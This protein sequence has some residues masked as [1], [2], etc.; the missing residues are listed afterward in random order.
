MT[1]CISTPTVEGV[2]YNVTYLLDYEL[3]LPVVDCTASAIK[4]GDATTAKLVYLLRLR[5]H[6]EDVALLSVA[7]SNQD[8]QGVSRGDRGSAAVTTL[9]LI[10]HANQHTTYDFALSLGYPYAAF[11]FRAYEFL[12][13]TSDS[14]WMV[15]RIPNSI[16]H[17]RNDPPV[18]L[19]TARRTGFYL[20]TE[21]MQSNIINNIW[22]L[23]SDPKDAIG[24]REWSGV[25]VSR[26]SW[27]WV[28]CI[29]LVL[30]TEVVFHLAVLLL[31][32]YNNLRL[33]KVWIGGPFAA[34]STTLLFRGALVLL[35]WV[36]D[37]FW[38]LLEFV[39]SDASLIS[40]AADV[41]IDPSIMHIDLLTIYLSC[42]GLVGNL[43]RERVD[44]AL[45][46]ILFEL[47]FQF[48]IRILTW[49]PSIAAKAIDSSMRNYMAGNLVSDDDSTLDS[50]MRAWGAHPMLA[51]DPVFVLA[52]LSPTLFS[53]L[54]V[55][56]YIG[57]RKI[58]FHLRRSRTSGQ[59]VVAVIPE[60]TTTK[61]SLPKLLTN[62]EVAT[63][64]VLTG[65]YGV[66]CDYT[67]YR[68]IKGMRYAS[69]DGIYMNGFVIS[70]SKYLIQTGDLPTILLMK[71]IRRR[72]RNVYI[73][74]VNQSSVQPLARL[75]YP[76]TLT[77]TDLVKLNLSVLS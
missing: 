69:A 38:S 41:L 26:D 1:R 23:E 28:H 46:V 31:I 67:N 15:R 4:V 44:P 75:V 71:L 40:P 32:M 33:G 50:P 2:A 49:V 59:A 21:A 54:L 14:Y 74:D 55:V 5:K 48:R 25:P 52:T 57:L 63:G 72:L 47:G 34:I 37:R 61:S 10:T 42:V 8:Y 35:T 9:A 66:L 18:T 30:A 60:E 11:N 77:W 65:Q 20:G 24:V 62:F 43:F 56:V 3:V 27:A 29:H 12:G 6:P 22:A 73:Y 51:R 36:V 19:L 70:H 13:V 39:S 17:G 58:Y 76:D 16:A 68:F 64:A 7:I 53:L 45:S